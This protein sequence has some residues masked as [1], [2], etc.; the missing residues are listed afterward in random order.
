MFK[1]A[2]AGLGKRSIV[3]NGLP[4]LKDPANHSETFGAAILCDE[5][6]SFCIALGANHVRSLRH[7]VRRVLR[8]GIRGDKIGLTIFRYPNRLP[9]TCSSSMTECHEY[10][11]ASLANLYGGQCGS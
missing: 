7:N 1:L 4:L 8:K 6:K 2:C 9:A 11:P 5:H 10:A 3:R